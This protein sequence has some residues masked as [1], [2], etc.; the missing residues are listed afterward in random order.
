MHPI[1]MR[2]ARCAGP[3]LVL[4]DPVHAVCLAEYTA[5]MLEGLYGHR[6]TLAS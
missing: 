1:W 5:S 2:F 4:T 3:V 6:E